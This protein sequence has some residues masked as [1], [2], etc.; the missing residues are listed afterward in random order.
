MRQLEPVSNLDEEA[1][2]SIQ[3]C[4]TPQ[5][6]PCDICF[7]FVEMIYDSATRASPEDQFNDQME[8]DGDSIDSIHRKIDILL[9]PDR[10]VYRDPQ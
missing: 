1:Q 9:S 10:Y 8:D 7:L 5:R 3:D 2:M 6:P 4:I